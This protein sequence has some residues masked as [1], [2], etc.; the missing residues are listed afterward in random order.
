MEN[1]ELNTTEEVMAEDYDPI[2]ELIIDLINERYQG[3]TFSDEIL[4]QIQEK[5]APNIRSVAETGVVDFVSGFFNT[6]KVT[7]KPRKRATAPKDSETPAEATPT[8][9][10]TTADTP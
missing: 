8:P 7:R 5:I 10:T 2:K 9:V 1:T 3:V 4:E 6:K